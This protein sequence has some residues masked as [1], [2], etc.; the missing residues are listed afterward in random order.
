MFHLDNN[1]GVSSM[2]AVGAMQD[3]TTRW[4][5]E[6]AGNQSPSWP[7]QDWF[8]IVQAELLNVLTESGITPVKT[9]F[10]QLA[11]AIKAIVN[12]NALLRDNLLSEIKALGVNSQAIAR[13]N[14]GLGTAALAD[15]QT[16]K[17]D[18]TS[19]RLL[20][21][22]SAISVRGLS[23][24][25]D[26]AGRTDFNTAPSNSVTFVYSGAAN[27]PG[28]AGSVVD[29]SGLS[30]N[31][32]IQIA[33]GYTTGKTLKFRARN[34]D[35]KQW[36]PWYEVFHTGRPPTAA[37]V[38]AL[39]IIGGSLTGALYVGTT[40]KKSSA[41]FTVKTITDSN[42]SGDGQTHIAYN[43]G[44]DTAPIYH[45]YFRGRGAT[46]ITTEAGCNVSTTLA[47][48]TT[49]TAKKTITPGDY[50]N[51]DARYYTRTQADARYIQDIDHTAPVEKQ[52]YDGQP[53]TNTHATDGAYL[54]NIRFVGGM[55]NVGWF[56]IRYTRKKINGTWYTLS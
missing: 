18:D 40:P 47:V 43:S 2:P 21:V 19:G 7:G 4:F 50:A 52:F 32:S 16:S 56:I 33:A 17:D 3:N 20:K 29:F 13:I 55:S 42:S 9:Q 15:V 46:N 31:Y 23:Y 6:G 48:G 38:G 49:I 35:T 24:G 53:Y 44:T 26:I 5:T 11:V 27:S 12:K 10:N 14:L 28:L 37:N 39:P 45:H 30:G 22:G 51:F 8:N 25:P 41:Q 36:N 1:S 34:G 54:A